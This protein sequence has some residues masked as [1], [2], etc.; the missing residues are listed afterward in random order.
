MGLAF[1]NSFVKNTVNSLTEVTNSTVSDVTQNLATNCAA[2]NTFE[3][4]FGIYPTSISPDGQINT[5][6]CIPRATVGGK[7]VNITQISKNNCSLTGGLTQE[8][9]DKITNDLSSNINQWLKSNAS[10]NNGFLGF[11]VS[12]AA[13]EG[14][15]DV[16]L[17]NMISNTLTTNLKQRCSSVLDASNKGKV[18]FCGDYPDGINIVQNS[19]NSNLTSCIINNTVIEVTKNK[20]LNDIVQKAAAQANASNEG[21]G[22]LFNWVKWLILAGVILAALI[23]VGVL[24]YFIFG[25]KGSGNKVPIGETIAGK[26]E[27]IRDLKRVYLEKKEGKGG[28][29]KGIEQKAERRVK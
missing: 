27:K 21:V 18:Y 20:V 15:N 25:S 5:S 16:E 19:F 12:I 13:A 26:K 23:I 3:G 14:I 11:G 29:F 1:S 6:Y 8:I 2:A 24:L 28:I 22:S 9:N 17:S 10:A 4:F 7:G